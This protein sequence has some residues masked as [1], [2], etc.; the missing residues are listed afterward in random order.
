MR[1]RKNRG[2]HVRRPPEGK[3][4]NL[5]VFLYELKKHARALTRLRRDLDQANS[6][7]WLA[8]WLNV[9]R[10][11]E[12]KS[13]PSVSANGPDRRKFTW[14][15]QGRTDIKTRKIAESALDEIERLSGENGYLDRIRR[16]QRCGRWLFAKHRAKRFCSDA[17]RGSAFRKTAEGKA[18]R[19][20]YMR[21]YRKGLKLR[22]EAS[23]KVSAKAGR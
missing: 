14:Q 11:P 3:G 4:D 2:L 20:A 5:D 9:P 23:L 17:C 18:K 13:E 21:D 15:F 12:L 19:A 22:E 6:G 16:C 10:M 1:N 7:E 8:S